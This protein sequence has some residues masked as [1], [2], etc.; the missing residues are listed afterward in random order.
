MPKL[1]TERQAPTFQGSL[2]YMNMAQNR[3]VI[4]AYID[5]FNR[6]D[7]NG[8]CLLFSP[9]AEIFGVLARGGLDKARPI[10]EELFRCF[11]M[12][13]R[14]EAMV[15]EGDSVAVRFLERGTFSSPFRGIPPTDKSY[16]VI[17][18]DWFVLRD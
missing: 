12:N 10:W 5:A 8:V 17:A 11:R 1:R 9:D 13:L 15:A 2:H 3:A 4:I 14:V 18:M 7:I 16:E 6:G